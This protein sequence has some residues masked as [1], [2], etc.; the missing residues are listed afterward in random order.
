MGVQT[1]Q[2]NRL[3]LVKTNIAVAATAAVARPCPVRRGPIRSTHCAGL[4]VSTCAGGGTVRLLVQEG[5]QPGDAQSQRHAIEN[6]LGV[7]A[8]NAAHAGR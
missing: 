6:V 7:A 8:V 1:C 5:I 2:P 3:A 4:G